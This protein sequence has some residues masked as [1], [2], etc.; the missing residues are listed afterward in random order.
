MLKFKA[1][2]LYI[3][4]KTKFELFKVGFVEMEYT[5]TTA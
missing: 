3:F 5:K 1:L 4:K 2:S